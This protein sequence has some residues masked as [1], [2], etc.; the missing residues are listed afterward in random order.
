VNKCD[1]DYW[2]LI[3][4]RGDASVHQQGKITLGPSSLL[5]W[6]C[7]KGLKRPKHEAEK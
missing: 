3:H 1:L 5:F 7:F 4:S 6:G 2:A